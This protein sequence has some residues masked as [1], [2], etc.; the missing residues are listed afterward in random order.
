MCFAPTEYLQH[1]CISL[2]PGNRNLIPMKAG[3]W[4]TLKNWHPISP[5]T[6]ASLQVAG[7]RR[8]GQAVRTTSPPTDVELLDVELWLLK[9]V[10]LDALSVDLPKACKGRA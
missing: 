8:E 6:T 1:P 3:D 10:E 4:L 2:R 7:V 9:D 5:S